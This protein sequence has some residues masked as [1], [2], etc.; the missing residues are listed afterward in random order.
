MIFPLRS[1]NLRNAP[2]RPNGGLA[3]LIGKAREQ[4]EG[5]PQIPIA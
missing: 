1:D 4:K 5:Y 3:F 2:L